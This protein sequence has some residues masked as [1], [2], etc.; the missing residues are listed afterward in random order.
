MKEHEIFI[1]PHTDDAVLFGSFRLLAHE[2]TVITVFDAVKQDL[3]PERRA[4]DQFA[5]GV[6]LGCEVRFCGLSDARTIEDRG[7]AANILLAIAGVMREPTRK[8]TTIWAPQDYGVALGNVHHEQVSR[9]ARLLYP[10]PWDD[11]APELRFYHT[12]TK[13]GKVSEQGEES[14]PLVPGHIRHK[15]KAMAEYKTQIETEKFGCW[16]HFMRDLREWVNPIDYTCQ[17][18]DRKE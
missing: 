1:S 13:Y 6:H 9:A 11:N 12:Y 7:V 18:M 16:P 3:V 17:L 14:A 15:L 8:L 2:S 10:D 5:I 4:E